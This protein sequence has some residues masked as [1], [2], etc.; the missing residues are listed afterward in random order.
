LTGARQAFDLC[1][2][3]A[4]RLRVGEQ[5]ESR[6]DELARRA[7]CHVWLSLVGGIWRGGNLFSD[8]AFCRACAKLPPP[9]TITKHF[10][11]AN[12]SLHCEV[13]AGAQLALASSRCSAN[14]GGEFL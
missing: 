1:R 12:A 13:V 10:K 14:P 9:A 3:A 2:V 11:P 8:S 7:A 5:A 6:N 4:I